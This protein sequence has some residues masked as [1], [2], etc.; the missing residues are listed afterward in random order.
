MKNKFLYYVL[1]FVTVIVFTSC[2]KAKNKQELKNNESAINLMNSNWTDIVSKSKEEQVNIYMWGGNSSV[3]K[4]IDEWAVPK[5]K[6]E[7]GISLN[8]VPIE[9]AR[10][11]LNKLLTEKQSAKQEGSMDIFWLNGDNFKIAKDN[12]LLWGPFVDKMPNYNK[13]VNKEA[14]DIKFDFGE[15]TRGLEAPFGKAQFVF[16]YDS[17][18]IKTPPKSMKELKKWVKENPGKFTYPAPPDFTGSAFIRHV[19]YETTGGYK[20]YLDPMEDEDFKNTSKLT[21]NYLNEIKSYLWIE[22]KT[23]PESSA[24][25][26]QLFAGNEIWMTMSYNPVHAANKFKTGEFPKSVRT[27]VLNE[28]TLS[29]THY[30]SIPFNAKHKAAAMVTIN[31]LLSPEAQLAKFDSKNW[32]D[33]TIL[34]YKKLSKEDKVKLT[35]MEGGAQVLSQE[36]LESAR[37]SEIPSKY[38]DLLEKGWIENV[39][40]K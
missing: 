39:A 8:R 15:D 29:N 27:F 38:V 28:G 22:G 31:F 3:N 20:Q 36:E 25:L 30:L 17:D 24:K 32:G 14:Y 18:K 11:M 13:Y 40:K 12:D 9:D 33:G 7:F 19:L 35:S 34:D 1:I 4:Y 2:G 16:I 5:L 23:Y 21:W 6:E 10:D 37:L 26:D